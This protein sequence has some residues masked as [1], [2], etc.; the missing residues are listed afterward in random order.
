M[1]N[2]MVR[3]LLRVFMTFVILPPQCSRLSK[4]NFFSWLELAGKTNIKLIEE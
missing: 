2:G 1:A 3:K 4:S